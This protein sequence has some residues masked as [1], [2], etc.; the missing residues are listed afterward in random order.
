MVAATDMDAARI[1]RFNVGGGCDQSDFLLAG[2]RGGRGFGS[3][4]HDAGHRPR[5][6][7]RSPTTYGH[8][9]RD[10]NGAPWPWGRSSC[11][12]MPSALVTVKR[13]LYD[14]CVLTS[15]ESASTTGFPDET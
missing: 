11:W 10:H 5:S 1:S 2:G 15:S 14:R 12:G 4:D 8:Y 13:Y 7:L 3:N 6:R 9:G